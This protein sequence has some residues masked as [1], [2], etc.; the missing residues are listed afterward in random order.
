[1]MGGHQ[2]MNVP[3]TQSILLRLIV[4]IAGLALPCT[5]NAFQADDVQTPQRKNRPRLNTPPVA[6]P[7]VR[8]ILPP[9]VVADEAEMAPFQIAIEKA[10]IGINNAYT[11]DGVRF[12]A[13]KVQLKNLA[14]KPLT[15]AATDI[16]LHVADK[17]LLTNDADG[18]LGTI[19]LRVGDRSYSVEKLKFP[20]TVTV[21]PGSQ[22]A[23]WTLFSG[24]ERNT[25]TVP[26]MELHVKT[27]SGLKATLNVNDEQIQK[28]M[29][30]RQRLGP[31]NA[32]AMITLAGDLDTINVQFLV[33]QMKAVQEA[34]SERLV[35]NQTGPNKIGEMLLYWLTLTVKNREGTN[36]VLEQ[37]PHPPKFLA[38]GIADS[39]FDEENI[40]EY[41]E[42]NFVLTQSVEDSVSIVLRDVFIRMNDRDL[43]HV[44][45]SS[46]P[47]IQQA[48]LWAT[49]RSA[50]RLPEAL[51]VQL[52]QSPDKHILR[53]TLL[54]IG[55][56]PTADLE[57][58][59]ASVDSLDEKKRELALRS[60]FKSQR[61]QAREATHQLVTNTFRPK[62]ERESATIQFDTTFPKN[63]VFVLKAMAED[64]RP[65]WNTALVQATRDPHEDVRV[66]AYEALEMVG[67][68]NIVAVLSRG[69]KD[70][71]VTV[72]ETAFAL[73]VKQGNPESEFIAV[74]YALATMK[75]NQ[76]SGITVSLIE[77]TR[78]ARFAPLLLKRLENSSNQN[79]VVSLLKLVGD[80]EVVRELFKRFDQLETYGQTT[81][82]QM[83]AT[84][85]LEELLPLLEK[86]LESKS[87][88]VRQAAIEQL[89]WEDENES[90]PMLVS[91]L[92]Q[93]LKSNESKPKTGNE[94]DEDLEESSAEEY[95]EEFRMICQA[96]GQ[97]G[98][99]NA[100]AALEEVREKVYPKGTPSQLS[101]IR[102]AFRIMFAQSPGW[103]SYQSGLYHLRRD[104]NEDAMK[105]F[106]FA[107]KIDPNLGPAYSSLANIQIR[108]KEY[109]DALKNFER[110]YEID[111][112]D[113]QAITGIG[114]CRAVAGDPDFGIQLIEETSWRFRDDYIFSYNTA[115]VYGR[116]VEALKKRE[117]IDYKLIK[118][119]EALSMTALNLAIK[120]GF[121]DFELM[122]TDN[123][124]DSF[125]ELKE[126][127]R[128]LKLGEE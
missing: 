72:Q 39:N 102:I 16:S 14:D 107:T 84:Y 94:D 23:H 116:A 24:I 101:A 59:F 60:L 127:Q 75:S 68:P 44:I 17:A 67:H 85:Q 36:R 86:C 45:R 79:Q 115:C 22:I 52:I 93:I 90:V 42:D 123:D 30:T 7:I 105:S 12:V 77:Q 122:S 47:L 103:G 37:Y 50:D 78:D 98:T 108:E 55:Q 76:L 10:E 71:S 49:W 53:V 32:L 99:P 124:L 113:G 64:F 5:V 63:R 11:T 96:L 66:T 1:M 80:D 82:L 125:R 91:A 6:P 54:A 100:E 87:L 56:H 95:Q 74:Q 120:T 61:P 27:K 21:P 114:I 31:G 19:S 28:L 48:A 121:D 34:G 118:E 97:I 35:I 81:V 43:Q 8:R 89:V 83:G 65:E 109:D 25:S 70:P 73:L 62:Q 15:V 88:D 110:A 92:N 20:E 33:D 51:L 117:K 69:L 111:E 46:E 40:D 29:L 106:R 4:L 104:Q 57:P 41:S 119:L 126:F 38:V 2:H 9:G 18:A 3:Q 58:L 13:I 112:Y 128:L 26:K